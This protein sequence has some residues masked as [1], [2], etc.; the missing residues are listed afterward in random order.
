MP[1][2]E[3]L[4]PKLVWKHFDEI[5]KIPRCSK[6]EE[7]IREYIVNFAQNQGLKTKVDHVGNVVVLKP[8][9][10]GME[11]KPT[12]VLQGHMDMVCEKNSDVTFDFS[13][14]PIQL[15]ITGDLLT[16]NGTTLGADN[17]IGLAISLA[18]LEDT[19]VRHGPIESLYTIDE[20]TGL[21]GAFAMKP[22]MLTGKIMLNLDSEDFGVIT[23]GCAGGGDSTLELPIHMQPVLGGSEH[24]V[25]KV[26]GLRG[27]HSGVD[28]HEQRGNAIKILTR[29]LW[30]ASQK[31]DF[32]IFDVKGGDKHNA[33]PREA[34]AKLALET[35]N[36]NSF[37]TELKA[38]EKDIYEE[39]KP[40]DPGFKVDVQSCDPPKTTL[41][42]PS[43]TKLLNLVHGLPH[44][45]HQMNY[46][47]KT[48]VN[49]STN[50][51]TISM[52]ENAVVIGMS[53]RSPMKSALQDM[54]DR[55]RA[56]A[57]LS[58]ATVSEGTPYPGWKPDLQSKILALSKKIF[59][60]M[61]KQE[62]KIEAIHAG[63]ECGIIG[64]KFPGMDMISIGPTLKNPHS[65]EEQLHISTVGKFYNFLLKVLEAV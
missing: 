31:C 20:E 65:P 44:G 41:D 39:I 47:I 10:P 51:A 42:K 2:I 45:V 61:F 37:V 3:N 5:R 46:D 49:T 19:T 25:V 17:G 40:I 13:K 30:K 24:I 59:K 62:P 50:L 26:F 60:D 56:I 48:L 6:H 15:K 7:R 35:K 34:Y 27:G 38:E 9:T 33:I 55:I 4:E 11:N 8:A 21:T 57:S 1:G 28:I 43:Q 36:K 64:E 54:R 16:A 14:D 29:L 23:V 18:I 53:S 12:V 58:G 32:F 22:D 52:K 63:L